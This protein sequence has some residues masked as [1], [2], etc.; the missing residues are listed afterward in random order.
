LRQRSPVGST[1][2]RRTQAS[3]ATSEDP[4]DLLISED[5]VELGAESEHASEAVPASS[6]GGDLTSEVED[7]EMEVDSQDAGSARLGESESESVDSDG[8]PENVE[9]SGSAEE[10]GS[11]FEGEEEGGESEEGSASGLSVEEDEKVDGRKRKQR[12]DAQKKPKK[13]TRR[14]KVTVSSA[15]LQTLVEMMALTFFTLFSHA[16]SHRPIA[17][18]P[19]NSAAIRTCNA[20]RQLSRSALVLSYAP[21]PPPAPPLPATLLLPLAL[22]HATTV[23][24]DCD[25]ASSP[26]LNAGLLPADVRYVLIANIALQQL[27]TH[28]LSPRFPTTTLDGRCMTSSVGTLYLSGSLELR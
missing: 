15:L 7:E 1:R 25:D 21:S 26:H 16:A 3:E 22:H 12:A 11:E 24:I 2:S 9:A 17:R 18:G 27:F 14:G 4:L 6:E 10:T 20:G 23:H 8:E 28:Q 5:K 13:R 19:S